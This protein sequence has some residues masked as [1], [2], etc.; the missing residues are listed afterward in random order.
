MFI[1]LPA[2]NPVA[3][4][5]TVCSITALMAVSF[6]E[7]PVM[8]CESVMPVALDIL[9]DILL[10]TDSICCRAAKLV[11]LVFSISLITASI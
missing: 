10:V 9:L 7:S 11:A 4:V 8:F 3:F 1:K 2:A 6:V 5:F